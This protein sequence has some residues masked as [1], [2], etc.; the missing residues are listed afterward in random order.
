MK[1]LLD[2]INQYADLLSQGAVWQD[3]KEIL[4][5]VLGDRMSDKAED[6]YIYEFY[7]YVCLIVDLRDSYDIRFVE[8]TGNFKYKFPQ[9]A[10]LKKGK[11]RFHAF[12]EDEMAFQICAGTKISCAYPSENNHPDIS[13]Q[14]PEA[15]D[16]PQDSDLII[17]MDAKFKEGKNA[18]LPKD[19]VYKFAFILSLY[20][21]KSLPGIKIHFKKLHE[22]YGNCLLTNARSYSAAGEVKMLQFANAKEIEKFFPY[23]IYN[24]IG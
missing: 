8:G 7:C 10:A 22:F 18:V 13:F 15:S 11:P 20:N 19:E 23:S 2:H 5:P 9:A 21:L 3:S 4:A 17:I 14:R 24:V 16:D 12:K 1:D 6:N